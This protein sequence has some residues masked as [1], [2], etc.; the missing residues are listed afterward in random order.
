[1]NRRW[2]WLTWLI[3]GQV[4]AIL[5]LVAF[6]IWRETLPG[7]VWTLHSG[8]APQR[9]EA[10]RQLGRLGPG[11]SQVLPA[12]MEALRDPNPAVQSAA[13]TAI[14]RVGGA[15]ALAEAMTSPNPVARVAVLGV[16]WGLPRDPLNDERRVEILVPALRDPSPQVRQSAARALAEMGPAAAPAVPALG[17]ALYDSDGSVRQSAVD[18]LARLGAL[19]ELAKAASSADPNVRRLALSNLPSFGARAIPVLNAALESEDPDNVMQAAAIL[20]YMQPPATAAVPSLARAL[21]RP[22]RQLQIRVVDS[23]E[24]IGGPDAEAALQQATGDPDLLVR[25]AALAAL[26]RMKRRSAP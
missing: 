11:A 10:A 22:E 15:P 8:S 25:S 2:P 9:V 21:Q 7:L 6:A 19:E 26:Q 1:M 4:A 23:L 17:A 12:L 24:R 13:A 18:A 5:L 20:G 16:L 14:G 3:A